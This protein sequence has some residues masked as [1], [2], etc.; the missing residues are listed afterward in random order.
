REAAGALDGH[1]TGRAG[2]LHYSLDL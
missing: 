1:L 2:G